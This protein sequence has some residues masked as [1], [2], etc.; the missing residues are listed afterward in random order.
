MAYIPDT[1]AAGYLRETETELPLPWA[2]S[3][4]RVKALITTS[5]H[6]ARGTRNGNPPHRPG[7]RG[8]N[9]SDPG[10]DR[11][12]VTVLLGKST[13]RGCAHRS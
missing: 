8:G 4:Q 2:A 10:E 13:R 7:Y 9:A 11:E 5:S 6:P 1:V 12:P 3:P